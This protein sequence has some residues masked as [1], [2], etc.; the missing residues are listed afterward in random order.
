MSLSR[1]PS[2]TQLMAMNV[3]LLHRVVDCQPAP[4][5]ARRP[6]LIVVIDDAL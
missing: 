5:A 4:E 1:F 2:P 3:N 6:I